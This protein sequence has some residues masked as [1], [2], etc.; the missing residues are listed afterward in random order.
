LAF[1]AVIMGTLGLFILTHRQTRSWSSL[2]A[3]VLIWLTLIGPWLLFRQSLPLEPALERFEWSRDEVWR[4]VH[5]LPL[6][7]R[8]FLQ[9]ASNPLSWGLIWVLWVVLSLVKWRQI[10]ATPLKYLYLIILG[11]LLAD[12]LAVAF[13]PVGHV[14]RSFFESRALARLLFQFAPL[15]V[16]LIL[17]LLAH[18][19]HGMA[20]TDKE[21]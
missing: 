2:A 18:E 9:E 19:K 6:V 11:G 21:A 13:A 3:F 12:L 16:F 7:T 10:L 5:N 4:T 17:H 8:F 15:A 1:S 20:P 14:E